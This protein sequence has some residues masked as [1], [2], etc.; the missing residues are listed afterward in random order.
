MIRD[1][2]VWFGVFSGRGGRP[3]TN[4]RFPQPAAGVAAILALGCDGAGGEGRRHFFFTLTGAFACAVLA[5]TYAGLFRRMG[6]GPKEALFWPAGVFCTPSWFYGTSTY[7]DILGRPRWCWPWPW[8][9][10]PDAAVRCSGR[11]PQG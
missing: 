6:L 3:Y 10:C 1:E 5:V 11:R 4:Y 2:R 9:W 8:P 7:D